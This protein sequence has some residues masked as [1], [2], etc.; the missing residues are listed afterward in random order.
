MKRE[1]W[2]YRSGSFVLTYATAR[3]AIMGFGDPTVFVMV[4]TAW[5]LKEVLNSDGVLRITIPHLLKKR[6]RNSSEKKKPLALSILNSLSC[7]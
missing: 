3:G 5:S 4:I 1:T 2:S 7:F 6:K